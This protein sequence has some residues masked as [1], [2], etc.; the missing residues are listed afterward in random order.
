MWTIPVFPETYLELLPSRIDLWNQKK[1]WVDTEYLWW[2][3]AKLG[4]IQW[5]CDRFPV[6]LPK[7][8][9]GDHIRL[10]RVGGSERSLLAPI[11]SYQ[12]IT[13]S[14][15]G[16][17][18]PLHQAGWPGAV[19]SLSS[20]YGAGGAPKSVRTP[21]TRLGAVTGVW[22]GNRKAGSP[23]TPANAWLWIVPLRS[24]WPKNHSIKQN[25]QDFQDHYLCP[26]SWAPT[27]TTE[28]VFLSPF[29]NFSVPSISSVF[30]LL[31]K[32]NNLKNN[33]TCPKINYSG[34][35]FQISL[36]QH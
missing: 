4:R 5:K 12:S 24:I 2:M 36:P 29:S 13:F 7:A 32:K 11:C 33:P 8:T 6:I 34:K 3:C 28:T 23:Q 35:E 10:Q 22:L 18:R 15:R 16:C 17:R 21:G 14:S 30:N 27:P 26:R 25:G 19:G 20:C 31:K 9:P 1:N